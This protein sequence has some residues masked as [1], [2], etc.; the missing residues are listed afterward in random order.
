MTIMVDLC[1]PHVKGPASSLCTGVLCGLGFV[2]GL[3]FPRLV[4][5]IGGYGAFW[6]FS[7]FCALG[8]IFVALFLPETKDKTMDEIQSL[9]KTKRPSSV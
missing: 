3:V 2:I 6:L 7:G 9:F 5:G 8:G 4:D 1:P